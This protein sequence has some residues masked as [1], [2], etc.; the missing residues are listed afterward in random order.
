M[1]NEHKELL[2][3]IQAAERVALAL[4]KRGEKVGSIVRTLRSAAAEVATRL[5]YY[6]SQPKQARPSAAAVN[7][8]A[9]LFSKK[10]D[11]LLALVMDHNTTPGNS[12]LVLP[13]DATKEQIVDAL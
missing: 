7:P 1:I 9:E 10:K 8:R 3:K 11:D 12:T 2:E 6:E 13:E 5:N 4:Q